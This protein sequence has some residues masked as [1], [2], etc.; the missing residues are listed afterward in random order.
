MLAPEACEVR[1]PSGRSAGSIDFR[2]P[3]ST[4]ERDAHA[5]YNCPTTTELYHRLRPGMG[6]QLVIVVFFDLVTL[7]DVIESNNT[8]FSLGYSTR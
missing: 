7:A 5:K 4:R 8:D 2:L 6:N 3:E 1:V